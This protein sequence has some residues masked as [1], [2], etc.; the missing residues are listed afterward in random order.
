MD[1]NLYNPKPQN[2]NSKNTGPQDKYYGK[3][4]EKNLVASI[5]T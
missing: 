2:Y 5:K 4:K 1:N 3:K